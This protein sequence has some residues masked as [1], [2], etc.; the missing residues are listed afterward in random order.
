MYGTYLWE[1]KMFY[2]LKHRATSNTLK[3]AVLTLRQLSAYP[4]I[5]GPKPGCHATKNAILASG[6]LSAKSLLGVT[7]REK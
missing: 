6:L 2:F 5:K 1:D 4:R 7:G 3:I